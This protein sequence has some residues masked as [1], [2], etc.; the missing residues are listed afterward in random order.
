GHT[1][2][3]VVAALEAMTGIETRRIH[4]D[5]GY[6]GHNHAQK[7]RVWISGQVRRVTATIRREMRRRAAVEPVIGH[8]KAEHRMGRN[9]LKG[10]DG[11]RINAVLAAAGYNFSLLLRWL[12]RL[13]RALIRALSAARA[14]SKPPKK[15]SSTVL[16]G[17]FDMHQLAGTR[18]LIAHHGNR[19]IERLQ[20]IEAEPAQD[21]CHCRDRQPEL[22]CDCRR[23][24][25]LPTQSFDR[26]DR[27]RSRRGRELRS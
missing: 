16:H 23:T 17:R 10:R 8:I 1:L 20:A 22:P 25:P 2:G 9:Y 27:L 24:G 4:V 18:S 11:D 6:R 13:L 15:R 7:F 21:L 19:W 26:R 5:K 12:E 3:P 14:G